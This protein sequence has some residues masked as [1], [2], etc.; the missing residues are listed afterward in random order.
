MSSVLGYMPVN[1]LGE[2]SQAFEIRSTTIPYQYLT[3]CE[4]SLPNQAILAVYPSRARSARTHWGKNNGSV[5]GVMSW[6]CPCRWYMVRVVTSLP[7][8]C[9]GQ[10]NRGQCLGALVGSGLQY[11]V[12]CYGHSNFYGGMLALPIA[13]RSGLALRSGC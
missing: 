13:Y 3:Q 10:Y 1:E 6:N 4:E 9:S 12:G 7:A 5:A 8:G 11:Q 2:P